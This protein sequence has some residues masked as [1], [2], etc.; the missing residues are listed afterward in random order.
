[1]RIRWVVA[2]VG[3]LAL[4]LDRVTMEMP[5]V[6][7]GRRGRGSSRRPAPRARPTRSP[8]TSASR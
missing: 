8:P 4:R 1:M 6:G 3:A 5:W 2:G 7:A